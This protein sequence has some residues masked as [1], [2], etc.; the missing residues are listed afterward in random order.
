MAKVVFIC[1][2]GVCFIR[3]LYSKSMLY[4]DG[5]CANLYKCQSDWPYEKKIYTNVGEKVET[6]ISNFPLCYSRLFN[7]M[8]N[9]LLSAVELVTFIIDFI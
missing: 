3:S 5:V 6:D 1:N 2:R 7:C 4:A 8:L 9:Q